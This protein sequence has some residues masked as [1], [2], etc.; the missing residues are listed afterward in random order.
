MQSKELEAS[1]AL[2]LPFVN[3]LG[4]ASMWL[5]SSFP[6][7]PQCRVVQD[8]LIQWHK[9][10]GKHQPSRFLTPDIHKEARPVGMAWSAL[11]SARSR[12]A[13]PD[14][15]LVLQ[16]PA[17]HGHVKIPA[18]IRHGLKSIVISIL[19]VLDCFWVLGASKCFCMSNVMY[20][21]VS[22][23]EVR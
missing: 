12:L 8:C 9:I 3:G 13:F 11:F 20:L 21:N 14:A 2:A 18:S 15:R 5:A 16:M 6:A 19:V 4:C 7:K 10:R 17:R 22:E 23:V 1:P